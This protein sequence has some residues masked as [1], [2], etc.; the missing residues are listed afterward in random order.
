MVPQV[1][2]KEP[3]KELFKA[4]SVVTVRCIIDTNHLMWQ[5]L[6]EFGNAMLI[7]TANSITQSN[8]PPPRP[9][10]PPLI[11]TSF[12][13]AKFDNQ[14]SWA[15]RLLNSSVNFTARLA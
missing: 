3:D 5:C 9:Y 14:D 10:L 15:V 11:H 6:F 8:P 12:K 13:R 1:K 2:L 7:L 4:G